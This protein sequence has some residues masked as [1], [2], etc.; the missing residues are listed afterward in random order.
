MQTKP[1]MI[2]QTIFTLLCLL[3]IIAC[4]CNRNNVQ[5]KLLSEQQLLKDSAFN[6]GER[7]Y[8]YASKGQNDSA[9]AGQVQLGAVY[10]RLIA[11]Q[12][13]LDSLDKLR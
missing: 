13:S 2:K 8:E 11:I 10:A 3:I 4:G 9:K 1:Y 6:I 5:T 12:S 7:V